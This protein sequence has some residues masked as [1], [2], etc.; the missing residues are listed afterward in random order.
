MGRCRVYERNDRRRV[1]RSR[2]RRKKRTT[3]ARLDRK[4][5]SR[6]R[7][8]YERS[9]RALL[10]IVASQCDDSLMPRKLGSLLVP[11]AHD[12]EQRLFERAATGSRHLA[13]G[14]LWEGSAPV[15]ACGDTRFVAVEDVDGAGRSDEGCQQH[16]D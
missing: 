2:D 16:D 10:A 5:S 11:T 4:G 1:E 13:G 9:F 3:C 6:R 7:P 8:R 15:W 12:N 14:P